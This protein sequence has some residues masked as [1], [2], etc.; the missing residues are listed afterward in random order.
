LLLGLLKADGG[1]A[2][3]FGVPLRDADSAID[4]RRRIGFVSEEKDLYPYMSVGEIIRFT[5]PFFPRWRDDLSDR[6][7]KMFD[8]PLKR[9]ISD[10]SKGMRSKLMLLLAL[11]HQPELLI[12]D[13]PT[14]G[15]DPAATEDMLRELVAVAASGST[16]IFFSSH[17]LNEVEQISDHICIIDHGASIVAGALDDI[18][19]RYQRLQVVFE[20]EVRTPA[21]W[22]EGVEHIRQEGRVVSILASSNVDAIVD[23]IQSLPVSKLERQPVSLKDIFLDHV[24]SN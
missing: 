3:V 24:R 23:Q 6:Y 10:L 16:T 5:R 15:L 21:K 17:H 19:L 11:S 14:D 18:R 1:V 8:L 7:L 4:I 2:S 20:S 12:L 13:E 9:R 22:V